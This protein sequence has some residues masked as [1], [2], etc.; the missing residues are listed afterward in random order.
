MTDI[1]SFPIATKPLVPS[2]YPQLKGEAGPATEW[3]STATHLQARPVGGDAWSDVVALSE[4]KGAKGDAGSNGRTILTT[5]GAPDNALG[6]GGDYALD[7]AAA[8]IYGPKASGVWPAGVLLKGAD[9]A[10]AELPAQI[11]SGEI[12]AGTETALRSYSPADVVSLIDEH[13]EGGGSVDLTPIPEYT[14]TGA[15]LTPVDGVL[16]IPLDGRVYSVTLTANVTSVLTTAPTA[17]EC[18]SAVVYINQDATGNRAFPFPSTWR[19]PGKAV[20]AITLTA[21]A[22]SELLLNS[23]PAGNIIARVTPDIGVVPT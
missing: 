12:T 18:G 8:L 4:L 5:L 7:I 20:T 16:T 10:D 6:A 23:T 1:T 14:E 17:P 3:R 2:E 22:Q 21:N 19:W 15:T 13:A 11:T 9:G